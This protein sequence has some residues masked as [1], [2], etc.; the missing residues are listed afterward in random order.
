MPYANLNE[1]YTTYTE[2]FPGSSLVGGAVSDNGST[3]DSIK[4]PFNV[5]NADPSDDFP[6][7]ATNYV[8]DNYNFKYSGKN[9][10]DVLDN[11]IKNI[12]NNN[13]KS[14]T[15]LSESPD[16]AVNTVRRS[17]IESQ[18]ETVQPISQNRPL[19]DK[20][21]DRPTGADVDDI[22]RSLNKERMTSDVGNDVKVI[23][24]PIANS[25]NNDYMNSE[26]A[27]LPANCS[28]ENCM[29]LLNHILACEKCTDKL[30]T[31]LGV[32]NT[33][34]IMGFQLPN[35]NLSK[36]MFWIVLII[37]IVAVYEL[38]NTLFRPFRR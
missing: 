29:T 23:G 36:L 11:Q 31:L 7:L 35:V 10:W 25:G 19:I 37:L 32:S 6:D 28:D 30:K 17:Q 38:L 20:L 5:S 24:A 15:F 8:P 1:A 18:I 21:W 4:N 16:R 14:N 2:S 3:L 26:M 33:G 27:T 12:N 13:D 9:E 34:K 22:K